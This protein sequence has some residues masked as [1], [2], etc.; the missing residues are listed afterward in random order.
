VT[1]GDGAHGVKLAQGAGRL[2]AHE[3]IA[4][5]QAVDV[6]AGLELPDIGVRG[7]LRFHAGV[8]VRM[9]A[10]RIVAQAG[11]GKAWLLQPSPATC[12]Y[13]GS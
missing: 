4:V 11:I 5:A 10:W 3:G 13:N 12:V 8:S 9:G 6:A 7:G 1:G 2:L